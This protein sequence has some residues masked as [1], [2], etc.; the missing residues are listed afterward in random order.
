MARIDGDASGEDIVDINHSN[1]NDILLIP[2]SP[3]SR[4]ARLL[5]PRADPRLTHFLQSRRS[6]LCLRNSGYST[7]SGFGDS[8]TPFAWC[9]RI[10]WGPITLHCLRR[11]RTDADIVEVL[12]PL[13]VGLNGTDFHG[14]RVAAIGGAQRAA[15][16]DKHV[17]ATCILDS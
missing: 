15:P 5:L 14:R 2:H 16:L 1:A 11:R 17:E 13:V 3:K 10:A 4:S 9:R 8:A 12:A 7:L 6:R